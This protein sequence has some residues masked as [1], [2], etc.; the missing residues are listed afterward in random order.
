MDALHE[1][2]ERRLEI[3]GLTIVSQIYVLCVAHRCTDCTTEEHLFAQAG[4]QWLVIQWQRSLYFKLWGSNHF[5]PEIIWKPLKTLLNLRLLTVSGVDQQFI[6]CFFC[7]LLL[8][9]FA[10][11]LDDDDSS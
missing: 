3:L 5:S 11:L 4:Q 8:S 1:Q 7:T 6:K 9:T 2:T 10:L